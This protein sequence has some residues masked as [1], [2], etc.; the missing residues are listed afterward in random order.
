MSGFTI[1]EGQIWTMR[2]FMCLW[3]VGAKIT[4]QV[5]NRSERKEFAFFDSGH[6]L[7]CFVN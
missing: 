7:S 2:D 1:H 4:I 6:E 3:G 5:V